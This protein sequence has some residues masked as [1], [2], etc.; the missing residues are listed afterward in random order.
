MDFPC[1]Y[2]QTDQP[3]TSPAAEFTSSPR[4]TPTSTY[5]QPAAGYDRVHER[6]AVRDFQQRRVHPRQPGQLRRTGQHQRHQRLHQPL[7][8]RA[9]R[10]FHS[11]IYGDPVEV[12][13][14]SI[15]LSYADGDIWDW[16][17][18]WPGGR[19]CRRWRNEVLGAAGQRAP[20]TR[21]MRRR[22][23]ERRRRPRPRRRHRH[24][25]RR[26]RRSARRLNRLALAWSRGRTTI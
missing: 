12:S 2:G 22:C 9:Q 1:S 4:S 25:R 23:P 11:A 17:V 13:G 19:R 16:T 14:T 24:H 10:Y 8:R 20:A 26:R 18:G 6:W 15:Q 3:A 7:R 21:P 5:V